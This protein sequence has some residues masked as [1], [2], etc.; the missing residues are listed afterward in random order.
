MDVRYR[1]YKVEEENLKED[2][3]NYIENMKIERIPIG[4]LPIMVSSKNCILDGMT[5]AE[6]IE[7]GECPL[8]M[9]GYFIVKGGEKAVVAQE[10][11]ASNFVYV[12]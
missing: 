10:R 8:D 2:E 3:R 5:E 1:I 9:G 6:K 4:R 12:F 7:I 11:M